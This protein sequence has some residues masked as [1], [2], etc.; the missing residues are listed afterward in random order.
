M[1]VRAFGA[2]RLIVWAIVAA[3]AAPLASAQRIP[4]R[5]TQPEDKTTGFR[6]NPRVLTAFKSVVATPGKSVVRILADDKPVALGTIVSA[7]GYIIT[8]NTQLPPDMAAIVILPG[9]KGV[10]A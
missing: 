3:C 5:R 4:G 10:E 7:D 8:K 6:E 1:N 9:G 2:G